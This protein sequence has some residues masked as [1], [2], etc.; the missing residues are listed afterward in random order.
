MLFHRAQ[1]MSWNHPDTGLQVAT[2]SWSP[3]ALQLSPLS[4][5][6]A[7]TSWASLTVHTGLPSRS[8]AHA[9]PRSCRP[10]SLICHHLI[11]SILTQSC[12]KLAVELEDRAVVQGRG[13]HCRRQEVRVLC[14]A[15]EVQSGTSDQL[16]NLPEPRAPCH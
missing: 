2:S 1:K 12:S 13:Q 5:S 9:C 14:W 10:L 7:H 15:C 16:V 8:E 3:W 4:D 11:L 6:S